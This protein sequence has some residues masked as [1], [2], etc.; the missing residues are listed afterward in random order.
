M[1]VALSVV[2]AVLIALLGVCAFIAFK[3]R[4]KKP[5]GLPLC[6]VLLA[7]MF[8]VAGNL[9]II[10]SPKEPLSL[11]G[12]YIYYIG[13]DILMIALI[14][15]AFDYCHFTWHVKTI[16]SVLY[17]V[18]TADI[19]QLLVNIFTHHAFTIELI[20]AYGA[21]FYDMIPLVGQ[22]VHRVIDYAILG[23]VLVLFIV[24]T[25]ITP[26]VYS[27][28]YLVI[29]IAMAIFG[30]MQTYF[31]FSNNPIDFSMIGFAIFGF[32]LFALSLYYRPLRLMDRMLAVIASKMSESLFFF[33]AS[34]RCVWANTKGYELL[35][36]EENE[37]NKVSDTLREKIGDFD[38]DD[39]EW[40]RNFTKG[41]GENFTSYAVEKHKVTDHKN[42]LVGYYISVRD[43]SSEQ[44][45]LLTE[46]FNAKHDALTKIYNRAGYDM[47]MEQVDLS[48]MFLILI[49][50][51]SFKN[52][53]DQHG[54]TVGDKVLIRITDSLCSHFRDEDYVCRIGGDE[55]AVIMP[56]VD[57]HMV[58]TVGERINNINRELTKFARELPPTT[59]SAGGAYGRDAEN[60]YELFNNADHALYE[61]KFNGKAGFT[62]FKTR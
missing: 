44:K 40:S 27:E 60:A 52:I 47:L 45:K 5:I 2:F 32:L 49:D 42:K 23:G 24:K 10:A 58:G 13:M 48:K 43:N 17:T 33:D 56:N 29:L 39:K 30:A 12:C 26:K 20:Q 8:P 22:T 14:R 11:T 21:D 53:N 9:L 18:L 59:I 46:S 38:K 4:K 6:L 36:I 16:K 1:R 25:V 57:E 51:D 50:G 28:K 34:L 62:I 61:T 19:I 41:E 37:L 54:H 15:F 3:K 7:L 55:F 31:I 35:G